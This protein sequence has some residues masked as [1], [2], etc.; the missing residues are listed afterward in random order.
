MA[1]WVLTLRKMQNANIAATAKQQHC[2]IRK[3]ATINRHPDITIPL[4]VQP[5]G[6]TGG[7]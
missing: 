7:R 4:I 3:I 1:L 5:F 6:S 2:K